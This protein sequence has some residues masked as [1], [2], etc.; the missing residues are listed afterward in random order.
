MFTGAEEIKT[1]E[2]AAI[3]GGTAGEQYDPCYHLACDTFDNVNAQA[4]EI[5]VV[6]IAYA[7]FN[8][9]A[10]TEAVNGVEGVEVKGITPDE[11]VFD[12]PQGTFLTGGGLSVGHG[13][14]SE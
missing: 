11:V 13:H 2:Q 8:L 4:L 9:A 1:E 5:N 10:S 14:A 3:W 7:I 12:G 6:A